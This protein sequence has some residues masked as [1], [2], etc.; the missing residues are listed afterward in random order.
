MKRL[1]NI[2]IIIIIALACIS[3]AGINLF[4][5]KETRESFVAMDTFVTVRLWGKGADEAAD[6]IKSLLIRLENEEFSRFKEGSNV[7]KLNSERNVK[8]KKLAGYIQAL[9]QI[10]KASAGKY[11]IRLGGV[12]SL[13]SFGENAI[14]PKD[15]KIKEELKR[16]SESE[17]VIEGENITF[18][19]EALLDLGS[20]AKGIALD[21]IK[22]LLEKSKIKYAL[23]SVGGSV[24]A[25]GNKAF[26]V[27]ITKPFSKTGEYAGTVELKNQC[28]STSGDYERYFEKDGVIYHH[29]LDPDTGYPAESTF[30]GCSVICD[31]G[32]L[33]DAL[34]T[35]CFCMSRQ[36]GEELAGK[37]G[38][39]V[40]YS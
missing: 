17:L 12:S 37:Y 14:I 39:R 31:S 40:I 27:G 35:C 36:E 19:G 32:M 15:E 22:E 2:K 7:Y 1:L 20:C 34:S 26:T 18:S 30:D 23:I 28:I 29:I 4:F 11:C 8:N 10:E 21:E 3:I 6:E 25:W 38:A 24:M 33:S 16:V 5:P 9:T 13:W